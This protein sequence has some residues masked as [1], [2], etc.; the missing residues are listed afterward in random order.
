MINAGGA[1]VYLHDDEWS[2]STVD[3]SLSAHFEHTVAVTDEGPR[4]LTTAAI[5]RPEPFCYH[6]FSPRSLAARV[7]MS[8]QPRSRGAVLTR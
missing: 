8:I 6:R 3:G 7:R 4:V 5:N 1:E 2:I